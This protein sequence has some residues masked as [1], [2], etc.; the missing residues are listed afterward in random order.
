MWSLVTF[1]VNLPTWIR[2]GLT[3]V[4]DLLRRLADPER[5]RR[6][7][8]LDALRST[9]DLAAFLSASE[10]R[11]SFDFGR[12]LESLTVESRLVIDPLLLDLDL[13]LLRERSSLPLLDDDELESEEL[14]DDEELER[15]DDELLEELLL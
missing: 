6:E 15:D 10:L 2:Q 5:E 9:D 14:L 11:R 8:S 4:G 3:G 12:S 13:R 1:L 7:R